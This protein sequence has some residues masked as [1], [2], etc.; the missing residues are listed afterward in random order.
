MVI[1]T[2]NVDEI[3]DIEIVHDQDPDDPRSWDNFGKMVC[4]HRKYKLGDKHHFDA[5]DYN[6]WE[7]MKKDII[8]SEDVC[9]ILPIYLY[10]HSGITIST[11][12]FSCPWDSGQVGW[13]YATKKDVR[14]EY[15][16]KY[17]SKAIKEKVE[18]ILRAEV[19]TYDKYINGRVYGYK[20]LRKG[21]LLANYY[22]YY[23]EDECESEAR[24]FIKS[25]YNEEV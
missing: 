15:R 2:I 6:G 25:L 7:E 24:Q 17:T 13:I 22:G 10:D 23:S 3:Y 21:E 18:D 4:F 16:T 5:D 11:K 20:I 19:D 12:P 9:V 1:E 14:S 8:K